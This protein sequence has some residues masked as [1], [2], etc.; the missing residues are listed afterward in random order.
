MSANNY[1]LVDR[2]K[3]KVSMRDADSGVAMGKILKAKSLEEAIDI[4]QSIQDGS[5]VEYGIIFKGK[6]SKK[7]KINLFDE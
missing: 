4:A 3:L 7:I 6:L 1:I 2:D 5:I